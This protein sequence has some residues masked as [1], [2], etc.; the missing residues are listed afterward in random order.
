MN[1]NDAQTLRDIRH[2]TSSLLERAE[3]LPQELAAMLREY[4]SEL[5]KGPS[6]RWDGIGDPAQYAGVAHHIGQSIADGKSSAGACLDHSLDTDR[7]LD[8]WYF[9]A[10]PRKNVEG[11]LQLLAVRGELDLKNG[12]HYVRSRDESS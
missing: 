5:G 9:R 7:S 6:R 1:G 11:A 10:H 3:W 12:M 4:A 2:F 8:T